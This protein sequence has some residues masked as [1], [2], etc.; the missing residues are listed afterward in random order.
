MGKY[1]WAIIF[2]TA[3]L[4]SNVNVQADQ[5]NKA[6]L[7]ADSVLRK[8]PL[9]E[10][11]RQLI[12]VSLPT[13]DPFTKSHMD[14]LRKLGYGGYVIPAHQRF[15]WELSDDITLNRPLISF[16]TEQAGFGDQKGFLY[17]SANTIEQ[18][19]DSYI[20]QELW[21]EAK[22]QHLFM[23][24][25]FMGYPGLEVAIQ[26]GELEVSTYTGAA[27]SRTSS[28]ILPPT[29]RLK[30]NVEL[31]KNGDL[32]LD[33][34][35]QNEDTIPEMAVIEFEGLFE[36]GTRQ[37]R[38][39]QDRFFQKYLNNIGPSYLFLARSDA[40]RSIEEQ[41]AILMMGCHM[42]QSEEPRQ[43][44]GRIL[45]AVQ[46]G[47]FPMDVFREKVRQVL[48]A[49]YLI[50][51]ETEDFELNLVE[52][53]YNNSEI[54][55][56]VY[57]NQLQ[58][59]DECKSND[60]PFRH[61]DQESFA[62]FIL[63][64]SMHEAFVQTVNAYVESPV[65][66]FNRQNPNIF[67]TLQLH[68]QLKAFNNVVVAI[69]Y[70]LQLNEIELLRKLS[71]E[72]HLILVDFNTLDDARYLVQSAHYYHVPDNN[73]LTEA[74]VPQVLFGA[75]GLEKPLR[76]SF[77][78]PKK[79]EMDASL[80]H[81]I[82]SLAQQ[83]IEAKAFPGCQVVVAR[84]NKVVF[85]QSYGHFTYDQMKRVDQND[86]YDLASLTK[87]AATTQAIMFLTDRDMISIDDPIGN[88]LDEL[89]GTDKENLIIKDILAHQSGLRAGF[90]FWQ[91]T[92]SEEEPEDTY[93][94]EFPQTKFDYM[95]SPGMYASPQLED[96]LWKWTIEMPLRR[97]YRWRRHLPYNYKYSDL[98]FMMM[99]K[100]AERVLN[101]PMDEFLSQNL[102]APLGMGRTLFNPLCQ[103]SQFD[104][105]PTEL[106]IYFRDELVWGTVHDQMAAMMGGVAGHAGLFGNAL[107]LAKLGEMM[108][109]GGSYANNHF[110]GPDVVNNFTQ[111]QFKKNRRGL[112]WD[113]KAKDPE[114][115]AASELA[116]EQ[117]Y[118]H[119]GFTGT[120]L[121]IDP[122]YDLVFVFLSNRVH[123][124]AANTKL[125]ELD[126][127]KKMHD[128]VYQSILK[129]DQPKLRSRN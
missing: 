2:F 123:P 79:A 129:Y 31:W 92:V 82:D 62:T 116:S 87:V 128:V 3:V 9:Q 4:C 68:E 119:T 16:K 124:N 55:E 14:S 10:A 99:Y 93:Y 24:A 122:E 37:E 78:V 7:W 49:K 1:F 118:G 126:V 34:L 102:Y 81:R 15:Q 23:G 20:L 107:D 127:R 46:S 35:K 6:S 61:T 30:G 105:A 97:Q 18:V 103:Y 125:M 85:N 90:P 110:Y 22:R 71:D 111:K 95:V 86:I 113:K 56:K 76:L 72:T 112:G 42:L 36:E 96:S 21:E 47:T 89:K 28:E 108:L 77:D 33:W 74:L 25:D 100:L 104:I 115:S 98:G 52:R 60:I 75:K 13:T 59:E 58:R 8:M 73:Y 41:L 88:Y 94:S 26:N 11:V 84:R 48:T 80:L 54:I 83:A 39:Q 32:V 43:I 65:Y 5:H 63:D 17:P 64:Y 67:E 29:F 117:S 27:Y 109:Q 45:S 12:M 66:Y 50:R 121:W 38:R 40:R 91:Y 101:Q 19:S 106:D 120:M 44:E 69:F 70:P 57:L 114:R 51:S 53:Y